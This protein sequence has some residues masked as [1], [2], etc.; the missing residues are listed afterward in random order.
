MAWSVELYY[1]AP[2]IERP[3][4]LGRTTR[5]ATGAHSALGLKPLSRIHVARN[6]SAEADICTY[7]RAVVQA[8]SLALRK[9]VI[10]KVVLIQFAYTR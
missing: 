10:C 8:A 4:V 3:I 9:R 7:S 2:K 5:P 6:A 1:C